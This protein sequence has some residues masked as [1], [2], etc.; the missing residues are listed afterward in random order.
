MIDHWDEEPDYEEEGEEPE[1]PR[2]SKIDE[3]KAVILDR[4]FKEGE[5]VYYARQIEIWLESVFFHWITARA[6]SELKNE[7]KIQ[8]IAEEVGKNK[9]NFYCPK[10][11]RYPR[12]Q[13]RS[14]KELIAEFSDPEFTRA[15][16]H[17]GEMLVESGFA[18]TGF[19]ISQ[20]KVRAVDGVT[21]TETKHDLDFLV[22]RDGVRYGVEVKNQLGYIDLTEFQIK[23]AMCEHFGIKPMFITRVMPKNYINDVYRDGGYSLLTVNQNYPLLGKGLARRVQE[24][25]GF[26]VAVIQRLPDTALVRF[27][28]WHERQLP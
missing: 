27:E 28:R 21:W 25:L 17:H 4:F 5:N 7:G 10:R 26:P 16:G 14:I 8:A 9:V 2:D 13:I 11:Y 12:R 1:R 20:Q 23:R 3:A 15:V 18:R 24:V 6:L 19:R 22:E